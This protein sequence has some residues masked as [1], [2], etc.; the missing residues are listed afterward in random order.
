MRRAQGN[1]LRIA[2]APD[3][4]EISFRVIGKERG[5]QAGPYLCDGE[6]SRSWILLLDASV[7]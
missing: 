7:P 2:L 6:S 3:D 1:E 4:P 5:H